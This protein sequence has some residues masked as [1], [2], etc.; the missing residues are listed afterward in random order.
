[1]NCY[2]GKIAIVTGGASGIGQAVCEALGRSGAVVI[3]S[4]INT[5]GAQQVADGIIQSGGKA[6][7]ARRLKQRMFALTGA[8]CFPCRLIRS[9]ISSMRRPCANIDLGV[10]SFG[11]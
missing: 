1:M 2:K 7:V 6:N 8:T 4:D 5:T 3:V 11:W 10:L 9:T